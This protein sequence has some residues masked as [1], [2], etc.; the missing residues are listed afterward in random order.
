MTTAETLQR[1][2]YQR[3]AHLYDAEH[4]NEADEHFC[5]LRYISGLVPVLDL[6]SV[7]DVGCGTGRAIKYFLEEHPQIR[8]HGI[9]PVDAMIQRAVHTNGV[10]A[11]LITQGFGEALPFPDKSF[12][13]T[14][15]C[16]ML[17]HVREPNRVL[18]EMMRVSRKAIFLSDGNRFGTGPTL[19]RWIKLL[20]HKARLFQGL[21]WLKTFGKAYRSSEGDGISY[22]YSVFDGFELLAEWADR[23]ILIPTGDQKATSVFHPLLTSLHVLVCAVRDRSPQ[24]GSIRSHEDVGT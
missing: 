5:A 9:E 2:Y 16:G 21:Y 20:L 4:V 7:L 1:E 6:S 8:I 23:I 19:T 12:D 17:H 14:L 13:A 15:E 3:T 24:V 10:P 18:Q 11:D 22:S